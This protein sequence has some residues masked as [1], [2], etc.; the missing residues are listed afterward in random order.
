MP[1]Q[2]RC[3][4]PSNEHTVT[5]KKYLLKLTTNWQQLM[6]RGTLCYIR[7]KSII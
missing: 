6:F 2:T 7:K 3:P 5:H 1:S 4:S